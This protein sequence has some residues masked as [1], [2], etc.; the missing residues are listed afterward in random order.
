[1][2]EPHPPGAGSSFAP[3]LIG[4]KPSFELALGPRLPTEHGN[5]IKVTKVASDHALMLTGARG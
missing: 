4:F 5:P 3:K 1:M 2:T